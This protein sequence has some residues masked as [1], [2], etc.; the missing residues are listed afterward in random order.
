MVAST[1]EEACGRYVDF[2]ARNDYPSK[3]L[4][5]TSEDILFT[6]HRLIYVRV[7]VPDRNLNAVRSLFDTA[8]KEQLG[9]SFSTVCIMGSVTCCKAWVPADEDERQRAMCPKDLK[10]SAATGISLLPGKPV[11]SRL[12]WWYVRVRYRKQQAGINDVFWG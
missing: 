12:L 2:L 7:P 1:F 9:I 8:T 3:L 4:W 6:D 11:R 10:L 5:V